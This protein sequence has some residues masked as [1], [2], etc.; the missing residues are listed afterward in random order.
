MNRFSVRIG[1]DWIGLSAG[2]LLIV[3]LFGP[4]LRIGQPNCHSVSLYKQLICRLPTATKS[5]LGKSDLAKLRLG[6]SDFGPYSHSLLRSLNQLSGRRRNAFACENHFQGSPVLEA[7][8]EEGFGI[9]GLVRDGAVLGLG[10]AFGASRPARPTP[11]RVVLVAL[12]QSFSAV[13]QRN[14]GS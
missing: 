12:S 1:S 5:H 9:P 11:G 13:C 4:H 8:V 3:R 7:R 2:C 6:K 10:K 14:R